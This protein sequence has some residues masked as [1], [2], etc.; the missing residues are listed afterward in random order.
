[1][2]AQTKQMTEGNPMPLIVSFAVPLM[3]GNIFQQL[4]SVVDS[5]V[6]G[7]NLGITALASLGV[8][9]WPSWI[10]IGMMQALSQGISIRLARNFGSKDY[11]GLKKSFYNAIVLS[12]VFMIVLLFVSQ[13]LALP[14]LRL[15]KTSPEL[16][17]NALKYLRIIYAGIPFTMA[18]N[19][20]AGSLRALGNSRTPLIAMACASVLNISLD[21]LFVMV[22]HWGIRGAA[23]A[24]V[25]A[26]ILSTII[27]FKTILAIPVIHFKK[28]HRV[29]QGKVLRDMLKISTPM[30]LQN[31]LIAGGGMVV[32]S[33]ANQF[34]V[35]FI[36]GFTA[37]SKMH[38]ILEIA[39]S[40]FGFA[41]TTYVAQ[42][43]GAGNLNR[44]HKGLRS[45]IIAALTTSVTISATMLFAGHWILSGF[46][47]GNAND[48]AATVNIGYRYLTFMCICLPVL[49]LL[50]IFRS[51]LQGLENT[52]FPMV[53]AFAEL[54]MRVSSVLI[55]SRLI[56]EDG[57][58]IAEVAAWCGAL[59]VLII[60]YF[61][62][63]RKVER[64]FQAE[65]A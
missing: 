57:I 51:S 40:S 43:L 19:L 14:M 25:L 17:P 58:F 50:Y 65:K 9:N 1:M 31:F 20:L 10:I 18:F 33:A 7:R 39:T 48:I 5:M 11:N 24:T 29:V 27:C 35:V 22:F 53:S 44:I 52:F 64:E 36:A 4:Y 8:S 62:V 42:N 6:V 45:G 12:S 32:Q 23:V 60:S 41:M 15:L 34:S 16:I 47:S 38:G 55:L 13:I 28:E 56:G 59:V 21:L 63:L 3:F 46:V 54:I 49:Y 37:G 2:K 30:I 26:Q 61:H